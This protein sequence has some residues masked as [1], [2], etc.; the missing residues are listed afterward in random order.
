MP[1]TIASLVTKATFCPSPLMLGDLPT[2]PPV[3]PG[4]GS[5]SSVVVPDCR[6]RT[7]TS[8]WPLSLSGVETRSE[9]WLVKAMKRPSSLITGGS[10]PTSSLPLPVP[11]AFTVTSCV[12]PACRSR[13]K[14]SDLPLLSLATRS[15]A[16]LMNTTKRP[17]PLIAKRVVEALAF[18]GDRVAR[19]AALGD[20][21]ERN[22][23]DLRVADEDVADAVAVAG[24]EVARF[25]DERDEPPVVADGRRLDPGV[26]DEPRPARR[27]PAAHRGADQVE[28]RRAAALPTPRWRCTR[29][30]ARAASRSPLP[31]ASWTGTLPWTDEGR[32]ASSLFLAQVD[33]L[34]IGALRPPQMREDDASTPDYRSFCTV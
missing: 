32:T 9:A 3:F 12:V 22:R 10:M 34:Q 5:D 27:G 7:K 1:G 2:P 15:L 11:A 18:A 29:S 24:H 6:S 16:S 20:A 21:D 30:G 19:P 8:G 33:S 17:L 23:A 4:A 31:I 13:T 28:P 25:A 14:M 26:P